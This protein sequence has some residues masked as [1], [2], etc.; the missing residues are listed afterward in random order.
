MDARLRGGSRHGGIVAQRAVP[1]LHHVHG[2]RGHRPVGGGASGEQRD[3]R[4]RGQRDQRNPGPHPFGSA[5]PVQD[6]PQRKAYHHAGSHHACRRGK[7][8]L[9]R[10]LDVLSRGA[11]A[12]SLLPCVQAGAVKRQ[13]LVHQ[14][15]LVEQV[16]QALRVQHRVPGFPGGDVN[17]PRPV[18]DLPDQAVPLCIRNQGLLPGDLRQGHLRVASRGLPAQEAFQGF[19]HAVGNREILRFQPGDVPQESQVPGSGGSSAAQ[20]NMPF[21]HPVLQRAL[22]F[23]RQQRRIRIV[24]HHHPEGIQQF[25]ILRHSLRRQRDGLPELIAAQRVILLADVQHGQVL[26]PAGIHADHHGGGVDHALRRSVHRADHLAVLQNLRRK[27]FLQRS[28]LYGQHHR[29]LPAPGHEDLRFKPVVFQHG[30]VGVHGQHALQ[31]RPVVA[32]GHPHGN[33]LPVGDF[34]VISQP[35]GHVQLIV[36][37]LGM[38]SLRPRGAK[39]GQQ[40][41]QNQSEG[42][43]PSGSFQH[44]YSS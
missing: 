8:V 16:H 30:G 13:V 3:H 36:G 14:H 26:R 10:N 21:P 37:N 24:Q 40:Q 27:D 18:P 1:P 12:P 15:L 5:V 19:V 31:I 17:T 29:A 35:D 7:H 20:Q 44:T 39:A 25:G 33:R 34:S 42:G 2:H 4:G 32:D 43:Q 23:L 41:A 6:H 38:D 28:R 22:L 9:Y 11:H